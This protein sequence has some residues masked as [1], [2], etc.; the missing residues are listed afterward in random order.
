M[1]G[2]GEIEPLSLR[3]QRS[4]IPINYYRLIAF[5]VRPPSHITGRLDRPLPPTLFQG[6]ALL[7]PSHRFY[8]FLLCFTTL[9]YLYRLYLVAL[10][11]SSFSSSRLFGL[12]P[13][14][15]LLSAFP[16]YPEA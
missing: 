11:I 5:G 9:G 2:K 3:W 7:H 4:V 10:S 1:S 13:R 8:G 16:Y 6:L 12:L 14:L 15:P